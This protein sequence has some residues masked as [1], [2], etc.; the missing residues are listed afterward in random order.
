MTN[1][2]TIFCDIDGCIL[3]QPQEFLEIFNK[4]YKPCTMLGTKEKLLEWHIKGYKIILTTGRPESLRKL[5]VDSLNQLG[6]LYDQLVMGV[7]SGVRILINDRE[8]ENIDK[9]IAINLNRNTG[10]KDVEI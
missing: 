5:T 4:T 8:I 9:A 3:W 10:L 7:G 2:K 6:I 1:Q